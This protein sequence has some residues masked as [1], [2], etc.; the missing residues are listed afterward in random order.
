MRIPAWAIFAG[1]AMG[2]VSATTPVRAQAYDPAYPVCLQVFGPFNY[3]ECRFASLA[4]CAPSASG[5]GA[6][7]I[8]NPYFVNATLKPPVR[9]HRRH[10]HTN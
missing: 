2:A 8:V 10:R 6:Q 9:R 1:L 4:E 3:N 5:R 7:C